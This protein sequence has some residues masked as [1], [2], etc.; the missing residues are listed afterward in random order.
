M[1]KR[2]LKILIRL[3][4]VLVVIGLIALIGFT[5]ICY[6]PLQGDADSLSLLV[7]DGVEF[8]LAGDYDDMKATGWIQANV[9]GTTRSIPRSG[10]R[11]GPRCPGSW[12][13]SRP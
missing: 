6:W 12:R 13:S 1:G 7:P 10:A 4:I 11:W 5:W 2:L 3:S 8:V 9:L